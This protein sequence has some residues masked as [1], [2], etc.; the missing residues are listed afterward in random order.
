MSNRRYRC[1]DAD[2][3]S[4]I[5]F[6][7]QMRDVHRY[8][9]RTIYENDNSDQS[10]SHSNNKSSEVPSSSMENSDGSSSHMN[11]AVDAS[12]ND[13]P[14]ERKRSDDEERT[15]R[16]RRHYDEYDESDG[17]YYE[18]EIPCAHYN[19][20]SYDVRE[21]YEYEDCDYSD[22]PYYYDDNVDSTYYDEPNLCLALE[23]VGGHE[24]NRVAL[25]DAFEPKPPLIIEEIFGCDTTF[26]EENIAEKKKKKK[27][28]KRKC[29]HKKGCNPKVKAESKDNA[30]E[31]SSEKILNQGMEDEDFAEENE[32]EEEDEEAE[33][34]ATDETSDESDNES[35]NDSANEA[36]D[37]ASDDLADETS[38]YSPNDASDEA[39]DDS[40]NEASDEASDSAAEIVDESPFEISDESAD[41]TSYDASD[42]ISVK[43]TDEISELSDVFSYETVAG[44][45]DETSNE[46][47]YTMSLSNTTYLLEDIRGM[48]NINETETDMEVDFGYLEKFVENRCETSPTLQLQWHQAVQVP[49][50]A[51]TASLTY[52]T[53]PLSGQSFLFDLRTRPS[54]EDIVHF[55]T[56]LSYSGD[57]HAD[58][59]LR[60]LAEKHLK[61]IKGKL[62]R[63]F[64]FN[65]EFLSRLGSIFCFGLL[66]Y[67]YM[68]RAEW[69]AQQEL[70]NRKR[71]YFF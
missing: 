35:S 16:R 20:A 50:Y 68:F 28:M 58:S 66:I 26:S 70:A 13:Y 54:V 53:R 59:I 57:I 25:Y 1:I 21:Y 17:Y 40:A 39:S 38:D 34:E 3:P 56:H 69:K 11:S 32:L 19:N 37:E 9:M 4:Q 29:S 42:D 45:S 52:T 47:A 31:A 6:R 63:F 8:R 2:C 22:Y 60:V 46:T 65:R 27:M 5:Q 15:P 48:Q 61:S 14:A 33:D 7:R 71:F 51:P 62:S 43:S 12:G 30:E 67:Y 55:Y 36:S 10:E 49:V 23:R 44:I 24:D 64:I 18:D 41:E